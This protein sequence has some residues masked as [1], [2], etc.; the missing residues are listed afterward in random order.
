MSPLR[1][2][3]EE[4]AAEIQDLK[5]E[6]VEAK[7]EGS[8]VQLLHPVH[9]MSQRYQPTQAGGWSASDQTAQRAG[10]SQ[11]MHL[12]KLP[13]PMG[14]MIPNNR[15]YQPRMDFYSKKDEQTVPVPTWVW[16]TLIEL[17]I[18]RI[19]SEAD[20]TFKDRMYEFLGIREADIVLL[21][22]LLQAGRKELNESRGYFHLLYSSENKWASSGERPNLFVMQANLS[23]DTH[24][25]E[26]IELM[27]ESDNGLA[28]DT[29]TFIS[30][31]WEG[32]ITRS[33][34]YSIYFN[35][36]GTGKGVPDSIFDH[37]GEAK[38]G[39]LIVFQKPSDQRLYPVR[40]YFNCIVTG[41]VVSGEAGNGNLFAGN[42]GTTETLYGEIV[43]EIVPDL[44]AGEQS[45]L[46][47]AQT[48]CSDVTE[49][50]ERHQD[51]SLMKGQ[52]LEVIDGVCI[53]HTGGLNSPE[54]IV[55]VYG[56]KQ[57]SLMALN[58]GVRW[59]DPSKPEAIRL[60]ATTYEAEEGDTLRKVADKF[61]TSLASLAHANSEVKKLFRSEEQL[62]V[63]TGPAIRLAALPPG[64]IE[65][66][67]ERDGIE[68]TQDSGEP[69]SVDRLFH[70]LGYRL[71]RNRY[72]QDY[73]PGMPIGPVENGKPADS[74]GTEPQVAGDGKWRYSKAIPYEK[75]LQGADLTAEGNVKN[76]NERHYR[77][78]GSLLQIRWDWMDMFGNRL[79]RPAGSKPGGEGYLAVPV[80]FTDPLLG[81]GQ[82]PTVTCD[83]EI[84]TQGNMPVLCINF[85]RQQRKFE[86]GPTDKDKCQAE[87]DADILQKAVAQLEHQLSDRE[88]VECTVWTSLMPAYKHKLS[89][90]KKQVIIRS[91][92]D[93][94]EKLRNLGRGDEEE[95]ESVY[96]IDIPILKEEINPLDIFELK[97]QLDLTRPLSLVDPA[98]RTSL[99]VWKF[100]GPIGPISDREEDSDDQR[101]SK[102]SLRHFA[103]NLESALHYEGSFAY[104]TA[105]GI[106]RKR[107]SQST[108]EV[109]V[110]LVRL[111]LEP[112]V[113][114]GLRFRV[115]NQELPA[116]YAPAPLINASVE[117]PY[118]KKW[119][120]KDNE[121]TEQ[122]EPSDE[123]KITVRTH[124]M[125]EKSRFFLEKLEKIINSP[126][127]AA[128]ELLSNTNS[129]ESARHHDDLLECKRK[130]AGYISQQM[131][132]VYE[133]ESFPEID[134]TVAREIYKQ[135]MLLELTRAYY[136]DAVIQYQAEARGKTDTGDP[137]KELESKLYGTV[138][139]SND[140]LPEGIV[141]SNPKVGIHPYD[142]AFTRSLLS[143]SL[144]GMK[145]DPAETTTTRFL[146]LKANYA[147]THIEHQIGSL[148]DI[149]GYRAS[150]W[151]YFILPENALGRRMLQPL[152]KVQV[153]MVLRAYPEIPTLKLQSMKD[154]LMAD[155]IKPPFTDLLKWNYEFSYTRT[156]HHPQDR[157][158]VD[159]RFNERLK[160]KLL[161]EEVHRHLCGALHDFQ[162]V[163]PKLQE[164]LD[165]I[166]KMAIPKTLADGSEPKEWEPISKIGKIL[167]GLVQ[168]VTD[169]WSSWPQ[170][171]ARLPVTNKPEETSD[172]DAEEYRF[173]IEEG[174]DHPG[175][176]LIVRFIERSANLYGEEPR[177]DVEGYTT[178]RS[179]SIK[180]DG[181]KQF[182]FTFR[183]DSG[184]L[185]GEAGLN[186]AKRTVTIPGLHVLKHQ[187]ARASV[188]IIR[189]EEL[190]PGKPTAEPFIYRTDRNKFEKVLLPY[191]RRDIPIP[192]TEERGKKPLFEHLNDFFST[193]FEQ[194][195]N[196][197]NPRIQLECFYSY[198]L[199]NH[200]YSVK[201]PIFLLPEKELAFKQELP[202]VATAIQ[203]YLT[204]EGLERR[205]GKFHF[206]LTILTPFDQDLSERSV[207]I[208]KLS[209]IYLNL[210]QVALPSNE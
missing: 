202:H 101:R 175:G 27:G 10:L 203:D 60:P 20:P 139:A 18:R 76:K 106:D 85:R 144:A 172:P 97:V 45:L 135:Q 176:K 100:S 155:T 174:S 193:L 200:L 52:D 29:H 199:P 24:P 61:G 169:M 8:R 30:K 72:Y 136:T 163:Y 115:L 104:R 128:F 103:E 151:L 6:S 89:K 84:V 189:N 166:S 36:E 3:M 33:G 146:E 95:K 59:D 109:P 148:P 158:K 141:L 19:S 94:E 134:R 209:D 28:T 205:G 152:G 108:L 167:S 23:T 1:I 206:D 57:D 79:H 195:G 67:A 143:F 38:V 153:P 127:M 77:E 54:D 44:F 37:Q 124:D 154:Y 198:E 11:P 201:I 150:S 165:N 92:K 81:P 4:Y 68:E 13:D 5:A 126:A 51:L 192:M 99:P 197:E 123:T 142:R 156:S 125:E 53:L 113:N 58:P 71:E 75:F 149:E 186:I 184:E 196:K 64:V 168:Y 194:A 88:M 34:G 138:V 70:L 90:K 132:E 171:K 74:E 140:K 111:S 121:I 47:L 208:L 40:P 122:A 93:A 46:D 177:I 55:R 86:E 49:I 137:V 207:P 21:E 65:I 80:G 204:K 120:V 129:S 188:Y 162:E 182:E 41:G 210:G 43:R 179:V 25:S 130:L 147:P 91:L 15:K 2:S 50:V 110:W 35:D 187:N 63:L 9:T 173:T 164:Y 56:V 98:F 73:D 78:I 7:I 118:T 42:T 14:S 39:L 131:V 183:N 159:V 22:R 114:E 105:V 178:E 185:S 191:L 145:K 157:V 17:R 119:L 16:A 69:D 66:Q 181:L 26:G 133:G 116:V 82:W 107:W 161:G 180:K 117:L 102:T 83:Y 190:V 96:T 32:S 31:L 112:T 62:S 87:R 12:W 48:Y 170:D 160:N